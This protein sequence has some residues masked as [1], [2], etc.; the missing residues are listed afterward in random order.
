M[1]VPARPVE[2]IDKLPE[3]MPGILSKRISGSPIR[4]RIANVGYEQEQFFKSS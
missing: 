4:L 1:A 3:E 2:C